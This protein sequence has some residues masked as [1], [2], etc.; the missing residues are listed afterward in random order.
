M[1]KIFLDV[2]VP[3]NARIYEFTADSFM[4]VG[5]VKEQFIAQISA[6][7]NQKIFADESQ[8]LFCSTQL[9]GL[10]QDQEILGEVGVKSGDTIILL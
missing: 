7:E 10:L 1:S 3:G 9:E 2:E 5:K 6:V 4:T 8:V